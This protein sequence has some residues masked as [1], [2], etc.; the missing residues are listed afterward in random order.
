MSKNK[1]SFVPELANA[2]KPVTVGADSDEPG[3]AELAYQLWLARGCPN[4]SDQE[5]WFIAES[6]LKSRREKDADVLHSHA[7]SG[8]R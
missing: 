2:P 6:I 8:S 5:D 3:I 4:G 1:K 7:A